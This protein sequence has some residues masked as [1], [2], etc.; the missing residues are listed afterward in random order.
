MILRVS[1]GYQK[2][3]QINYNQARPRKHLANPRHSPPTQKYSQYTSVLPM[4]NEQHSWLELSNL[5]LS[6]ITSFRNAQTF[7][8]SRD[9][10]AQHS[11]QIEASHDYIISLLNIGKDRFLYTILCIPCMFC[12]RTPA[13]Q[14]RPIQHAWR[15][16]HWFCPPVTYTSTLA[17]WF[18]HAKPLCFAQMFLK[19][20]K[21][22]STR[23]TDSG[24]CALENL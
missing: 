19:F 24:S 20:S 17:L 10:K 21:A 3:T 15:H 2:S 9:Q 14:N 23:R 13:P 4:N 6:V 7:L 12:Q 8:E 1:K 22:C 5:N 18:P 16:L 11:V